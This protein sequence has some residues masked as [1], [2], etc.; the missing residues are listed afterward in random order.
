M[1]IDAHTAAIV[2]LAWARHF[3]GPDELLDVAGA[4]T[5]ERPDAESLT[6]VRLFDVGVLAGPAALLALADGRGDD[7]LAEPSGL[8]AVAAD[9]PGARASV[10]AA[11]AYTDDF[12]NH[13]DLPTAA[14]ADDPDLLTELESGCPPDDVEDAAVG[15]AERWFVLVR[16][17]VPVAAAGYTV[18]GGLVAT[19]T[20]LAALDERG[21]GAGGLIAAAAT[22]DAL[23]SGF[24]P[25]WRTRSIAGR[26]RRLA[27]RLGYQHVG[28]QT[29][30]QLR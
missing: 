4:V 9:E 15:A 8:L 26:R 10:V 3:G 14:I 1:T 12:V 18:W 6:F 19:L 21:T 16:D 25:E 28:T 17:D 20:V 24:V 23:E 13:P 2:R 29:T 7:D 30:V 27:S 11:L 22:N 5:V